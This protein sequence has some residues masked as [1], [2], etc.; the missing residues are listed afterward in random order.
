MNCKD[1]VALVTGAGVGIGE[2]TS[3]SLAAAGAI[4]VVSDID[5][6]AG[7]RVA[8]ELNAAGCQAVFMHLDVCDEAQWA[9]VINDIVERFGRLQILINNAG[10]SKICSKEDETF[11]RWRKTNRKNSDAVFL[12]TREEIRVM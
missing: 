7:N 2:A 5:E 3:K 9:G 11:A 10:I 1:K 6:V 8:N 12:R 4:V